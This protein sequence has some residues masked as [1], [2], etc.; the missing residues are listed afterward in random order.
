M[1][2]IEAQHQ[3]NLADGILIL[4]DHLTALLQLQLIDILLG[5]HVHIF[6]EQNLQG[7]TGHG[8][9]LANLCNSSWLVDSLVNVSQ[10]LF[11][12]L[13]FVTLSGDGRWLIRL[14]TVSCSRQSIRLFI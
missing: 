12:K 14:L 9:L 13:V 4:A 2:G 7:G 5:R 6:L 10:H 8:E 3:S 11:K 1:N